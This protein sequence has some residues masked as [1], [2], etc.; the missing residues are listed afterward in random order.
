MASFRGVSFTVTSKQ[1]LIVFFSGLAL[2]AGVI[3]PINIRADIYGLFRPAQGRQLGIYGEERITK[4]LHSLRYIPENFDAVLLGSSVSDNLE[5][6]NFAGYRV[7]NASI[8]GGNV[9]DLR[10]I[11]ENVFRARTHMKLTIFCVHRFL[12]RDHERKTE[13][14]T[15]RQ[16]WG[17]LGSPQLINAYASLIAIR[18]GYVPQN[19]DDHGTLHYESPSEERARQSISATVKEIQKGTATVGDYH[20]DPIALTELKRMLEAARDH[21]ERV[22]VFHPPIPAAVLAV[23]SAEYAQYRETVNQLLRPTD[24]V[25]DFNSPEYAEM[26]ASNANFIDAVHLSQTGARAV[27]SELERAVAPVGNSIT[28][29]IE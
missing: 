21:S 3:V 27:V 28:G 22:V 19:Y 25:I 5:T 7:Y 15:P 13:L 24:T 17:A 14:M 26:R 12:T 8:N 16:Y 23:R 9:E 20:V 6:R 2:A 4:Y 1:F 29:G 10:P 11:A 18:S